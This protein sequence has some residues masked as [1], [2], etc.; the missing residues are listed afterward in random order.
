MVRLEE[1]KD[2]EKMFLICIED[3][4]IKHIKFYKLFYNTNK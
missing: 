1:D 3:Q 4:C 2:G